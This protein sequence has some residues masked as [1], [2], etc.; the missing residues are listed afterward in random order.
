MLK[1]ILF[2]L[3]LAAGAAG[4]VSWLLSEPGATAAPLTTAD[5]LQDRLRARLQ[6]LRSR[7]GEALVEGERVGGATET[8]LRRELDGYRS[9]AGRPV[10]S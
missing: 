6:E 8:R 4:A 2:V 10:T 5:S 3:G 7:F 1:V 9:A